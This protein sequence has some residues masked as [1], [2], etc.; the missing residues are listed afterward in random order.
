MCSVISVGQ[1]QLSLVSLPLFFHL[2]NTHEQ[3]FSGVCFNM[4]QSLSNNSL[5]K[6]K[7]GQGKKP[8]LIIE[9]S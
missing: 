9:P 6:N 3:F 7:A 5:E 1:D 8:S 4:S 2:Q